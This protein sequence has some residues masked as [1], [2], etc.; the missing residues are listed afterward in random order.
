MTVGP[1]GRNLLRISFVNSLAPDVS[2]DIMHAAMKG[3]FPLLLLALGACGNLTMSEEPRTLAKSP[4]GQQT[5]S[6]QVQ[7][8]RAQGVVDNPGATSDTAGLAAAQPLATD[9][10]KKFEYVDVYTDLGDPTGMRELVRYLL[11][12]EVWTLVKC[13]MTSD[14]AKH[15]RFQRISTGE[16]RVMPEVD[17]FKNRR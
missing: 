13:E 11:H 8:L 1:F 14:T 15:Y 7:A 2:V 12:P 9:P 16:G 4:T 17:I 10:S 6:Q 5:S 3:P